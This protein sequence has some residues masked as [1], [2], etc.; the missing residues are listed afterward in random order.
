M[1]NLPW[2]TRVLKFLAF[3]VSSL[4]IKDTYFLYGYYRCKES[5]KHKFWK[6]FKQVYRFIIMCFMT[7]GG[8]L[9]FAPAI[10]NKRSDVKFIAFGMGAYSVVIVVEVFW[11]QKNTFR[12]T[13]LI[14]QVI[15]QLPEKEISLLRRCDFRGFWW[16]MLGCLIPMFISTVFMFNDDSGYLDVLFMSIA[17]KVLSILSY[18]LFFFYVIWTGHFYWTTLTVAT[19]YAADCKNQIEKICKRTL[20]REEIPSERTFDEIMKKLDKYFSFVK[21]INRLVGAIPLAMFTVLFFNILIGVSFVTMQD[22]SSFIIVYTPLLCTIGNQLYCI[23]QAV[24]AACKA[25]DLIENAK[26]IAYRF[27]CKKLPNTSNAA[28]MESRRSLTVLLQGP[29]AV[30]FTAQNVFDLTPST[31]LGFMNAVIPFTVM[32]ITT[33]FQ[34]IRIETPSVAPSRTIH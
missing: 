28:L 29:C 4:E 15:D 34:A 12:M 19:A 21:E 17:E 30:R 9:S 26:F 10:S 24:C 2:N 3:D 11:I 6:R 33:I 20:T 16:R 18:A 27:A 8:L 22:S 13:R 31:I 1:I 32:F 25:T 7:A 14:S 23:C 5:S